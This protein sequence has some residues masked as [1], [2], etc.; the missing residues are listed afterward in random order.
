MIHEVD[1]DIPATTNDAGH[2]SN[3]NFCK[4]ATGF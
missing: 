3:W 2:E 1:T 4:A